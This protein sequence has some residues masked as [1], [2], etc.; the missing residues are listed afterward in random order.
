METEK[1]LS[2]FTDILRPRREE[3]SNLMW[4]SRTLHLAVAYKRD[5]KPNPNWIKQQVLDSVR[6]QEIIENV[7]MVMICYEIVFIL[8]FVDLFGWRC[9][10]IGTVATNK[11]NT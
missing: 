1:N 10:E 9:F 8:F 3:C 11:V 2:S 6:M 4:V 7:N 5:V